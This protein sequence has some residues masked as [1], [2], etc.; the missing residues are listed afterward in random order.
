MDIVE[1][2]DQSIGEVRTESLDLSFGEIVNLHS[3]KELIIH[4]DYQRLFRWT[5][6]QRSRLIESIILELPVPQIFVIENEDGVLELID[7]LQRVSSVIQFID[8]EKLA[9]DPL[10]LSGC[11]LIKELDGQKFSDLPLTVRLRIKRSS[12]RTI[13]IKRQSKPFLKYEMFKRLNTGGAILA[14]QEIRNCSAR[15]I[16]DMGDNFYAFLKECASLPQFRI[17]TETLSQSDYDKKGDEEL[18][19]RFFATKNGSALFKGSVRDWLDNFMEQILLE[20]IN[21]DFAKE[22]AEFLRVFS[23][24]ERAIGAG[25]FVKYRGES[26]IGALAPAYYEAVSI[27]VWRALTNDA[28]LVED[29]VRTA[30][31]QTVQTEAFRNNTGPGANSKEKLEGRISS[32]ENAI[33]EA[34]RV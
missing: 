13:M 27:G 1:I 29:K 30:I 20:I 31:I 23:F 9:M 18:V 19:L 17:C 25:S 24:L 5:S 34:H 6:E 8:A 21:F 32:I 11:D 26:P 22:T 10:V 15:M 33:V 4:P 14:P 7:G 12:V 16:G 28:N 2:I 3:S